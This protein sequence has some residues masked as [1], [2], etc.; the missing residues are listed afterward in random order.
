M[1]KSQIKVFEELL[2]DESFRGK[3]QLKH[4]LWLNTSEQKF[5]KG[6]CFIVSDPGHIVFG[7]PVRNFKAMVDK[8]TAWIHTDEWYYHLTMEIECN[9]K[10]T[11]VDVCKYES[12]LT[13]SQKCDD[14][15]NVLGEPK[16]EHAD[17]IA[18]HI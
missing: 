1:K 14:N 6:D 10:K 17:A 5:K 15:V 3:K 4:L 18:I 12:E 11:T 8:V 16:S 2:Q 13:R 9:G 7:Y